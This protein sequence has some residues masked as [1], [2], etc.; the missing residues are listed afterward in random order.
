MPFR[1][2]HLAARWYPDGWDGLTLRQLLEVVPG[3]Q[4]GMSKGQVDMFIGSFGL[5]MATRGVPHPPH[6]DDVLCACGEWWFASAVMCRCG[7]GLS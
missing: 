3:A 5:W 6:Y 1:R 2:E 7:M 4:G